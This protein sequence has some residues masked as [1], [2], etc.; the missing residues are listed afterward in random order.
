MGWCRVNPAPS[1]RE[2]KISA[3]WLASN[4][5]PWDEPTRHALA[6]L[7]DRLAEADHREKRPGA[8]HYV[9]P[10]RGTQY[11]SE[12]DPYYQLPTEGEAAHIQVSRARFPKVLALCG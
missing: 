12:A 3:Q 4:I 1:K 5:H 6:E 2:R 11:K 10:F 8:V 7:H 9:T